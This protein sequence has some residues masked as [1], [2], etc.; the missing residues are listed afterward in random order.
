MACEPFQVSNLTFDPCLMVT[1]TVIIL[2]ISHIYI[3]VFSFT[4]VD[5]FTKCVENVYA[6]ENMS[7]KA[8]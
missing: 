7:V 8:F 5:I 3:N 4:Y 2:K 1:S 6:Y